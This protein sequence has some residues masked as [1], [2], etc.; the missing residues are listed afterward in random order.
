MNICRFEETDQLP[1]SK[2]HFISEGIEHT[3]NYD[4]SID[5]TI[6][7]T[8]YVVMLESIKIKTY[9]YMARWSK[10]WVELCGKIVNTSQ[11]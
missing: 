2:T 11:K 1:L 5:E 3:L 8:E 10:K 6:W 9:P 4:S 7:N